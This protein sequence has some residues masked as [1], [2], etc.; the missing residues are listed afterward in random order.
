MSM[1]KAPEGSEWVQHVFTAPQKLC[2]C[3]EKRLRVT[4]RR[5]R[6]V[7]KFDG[8]HLLVMRDKR[9]AGRDC[10][11][12]KVVYRPPEELKFALKKDIFGLDVVL[13]IGELRLRGN[14]S[15][16]EIHKRLLDRGL[17]ISERTVSDIFERFLALMNCR[18]AESPAVRKRLSAQGGMI[19]LIDGV[20]FDDHS[21]VLYVVT[22]VISHT[23]LF[24]ERHEIR[25]AEALRPLLERLKAMDV[26]IL[27]FVTDKEKGLVPAIHAVFPD[28]PHQ[29]CQPHFIK[30]C[31]E[32]LEKPLTVLGTEVARAAEKLRALRRKLDN[33][34]FKPAP[35]P[36]ER[37]VASE[38]LLAAHAASKVAGRA[39]FAPPP[40]KR[41]ERLLAVAEAATQ[42]AAKKGGPG[43]SSSRSSAR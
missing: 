40:L 3:C 18:N 6:H 35:S 16:S 8:L 29:F 11:G 2:R 33:G 32:P 23:T 37:E 21:P 10:P 19:V 38:L 15:F 31:A 20:Q 42:A 5:G 34:D 9:C 41:H 12:R 36:A 24:A 28:V 22:D 30:R 1:P 25:S 13:E 43:P 14:L 17:S 4:Q 7:Q 26:P 39:P 27:A